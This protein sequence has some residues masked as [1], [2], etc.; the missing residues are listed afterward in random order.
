MARAKVRCSDFSA[1]KAHDF[2]SSS[3][4]PLVFFSARSALENALNGEEHMLDENNVVGLTQR[5]ELDGNHRVLRRLE[6]KNEVPALAGC[7]SDEAV[8][9]VVDVET[10]GIDPIVDQVIELAVRRFR[11]DGTGHI[12]EIERAWCWREDPGR[13]LDPEITRLTGLTDADLVGRRID[14][15]AAEA[16]L[17]SA[18]VVIAHNAAFDRKFI[19]RRLNGAVG[20]AWC[21]SCR[22]VDWA[23]GGF[24]G[25][26]LGWLCAQAG[27]FFNGHRAE[28][29]VDAVLML[30]GLNMQDGR[31]ALRE[32]LD[33]AGET[34][35]LIRAVGASFDVKDKLRARGYRW[36][37]FERVWSKEVFA[38]HLVR[39][40]SWLTEHVYSPE[41]RPRAFGPHLVEQTWRERHA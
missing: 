17:R 27:W 31:T 23:A 38:S 28:S 25:R 26:S 19:E 1:L 3:P 13:S 32:L 11:F 34:S 16:L 9:I 37:A 15:D 36:N 12:L 24:D 33:T 20:L 39:E 5:L 30:L 6:L 8:G 10:T 7:E 29:D 21:C 41:Y 35:T 40:E 18:Q 4:I 2:F 22:E 14:D